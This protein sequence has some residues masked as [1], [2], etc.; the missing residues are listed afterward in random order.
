MIGLTPEQ[1]QL[2]WQCAVELA[3]DRRITAR[4][5]KTAM[6]ALQ[7]GETGKPTARKTRQSRAQERQLINDAIG[8]LLVLLSQRASHQVLTEKVEALHGHI[9]A[10]FPTGK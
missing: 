4:L 1:A 2:A 3:G 8:Q 9:Q 5:V 10:L 6:Q 7:L